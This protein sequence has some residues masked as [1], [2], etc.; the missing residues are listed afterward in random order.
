[1]V[2]AVSIDREGKVTRVRV[3]KSLSAGLDKSAIETVE[4][5]K[6]NPV[7]SGAKPPFEDLRLH[8]LFVPV[9]NPNF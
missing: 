1:M 9:C 4:T 2:L 3:I 7:D 6:F 5:W 8:I